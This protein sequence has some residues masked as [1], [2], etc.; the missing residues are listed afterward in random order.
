M[1]TKTRWGI[2]ATG[3]VSNKFAE[4]LKLIPE[5]EL[6][7]VGSRPDGATPEGRHDFA[8]SVWEWTST[9]EDEGW[10]LKGGSWREWNPANLRSASRMILPADETTSDIGFRCVRDVRE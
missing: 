10:V 8:G 5:A 9:S 3:W 6:A 7:A 4:A 2:I 1:S